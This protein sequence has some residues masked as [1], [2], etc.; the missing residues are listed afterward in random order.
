M[1]VLG[2]VGMYVLLV[3]YYSVTSRSRHGQVMLDSLIT[4]RQCPGLG[5]A[6]RA[7]SHVLRSII[8][9]VGDNCLGTVQYSTRLAPPMIMVGQR[10]N[11]PAKS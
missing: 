4:V 8:Q 2:N 11:E 10:N 6:A 3:R 5:I 7:C 9:A 1:I